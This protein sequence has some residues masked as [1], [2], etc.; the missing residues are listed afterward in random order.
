LPHFVPAAQLLIPPLHRAAGTTADSW[1]CT[2]LPPTA[3]T[4]VLPR[5]RGAARVTHTLR[6]R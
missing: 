6:R 3:T 4:Q 1:P 5:I 2:A